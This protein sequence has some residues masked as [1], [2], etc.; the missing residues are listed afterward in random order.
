[1]IE[2]DITIELT[3]LAIESLSATSQRLPFG[4]DTAIV[5]LIRRERS[6]FLKCPVDRTELDGTVESVECILDGTIYCKQCASL[7]AD[8]DEKCWVCNLMSF[9]E[10]L[11]LSG[12]L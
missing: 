4:D 7:L 11:E 9:R 8:Q 3:D 2:F 12:S 5:E 6:L 1:M 10:I